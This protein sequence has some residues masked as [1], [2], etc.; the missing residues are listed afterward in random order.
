MNPRKAEQWL[1]AA[2]DGELSP[3]QLERLD[4]YLSSHPEL[5]ALQEQWRALGDT[6]RS[7][8]EAPGQTPEAA[9]QDVRRAIRLAGETA[10]EESVAMG[11]RIRWAG[12]VA[13]AALLILGLYALLP[14]T[15]MIYQDRIAQSDRTE[16]EWVETELPDAMSMVYEDEDT[17][18]TVIWVLVAE[19]GVKDK[20]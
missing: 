20:G 3:R 5:S 14:S 1:S 10:T 12:A 15:R 6:V 11:R 7:A 2:L 8:Q 4:Q 17:G 19:N 9:W 18:L 13:V 16:V